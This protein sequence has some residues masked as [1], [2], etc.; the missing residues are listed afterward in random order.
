MIEEADQRLQQWL[1]EVA[2]ATPVS[3]ARPAPATDAAVIHLHLLTIAP[4]SQVSTSRRVLL[5]VMLRYL[6]T[7]SGADVGEA[8]RLLGVLLA[9]AAQKPD[10]EI[11]LTPFPWT[12]WTALGLAPQPSFVL[13]EPLEFRREPAPMPLVKHFQ[14]SFSE[15]QPLSGIVVGPGDVPVPGAVIRVPGTRTAATTDYRGRFRLA[16][17]PVRPAVAKLQVRAKNQDFVVQLR[18]DEPY[19]E[20]LVIHYQ[21]GEV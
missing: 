16:G 12:F 19:P 18:K 9:A 14:P 15:L 10:C 1:Q 20:C 8:H 6:V 21:P 4:G 13:C 7:V 11:D 5:T 3:L 2:P 17:V